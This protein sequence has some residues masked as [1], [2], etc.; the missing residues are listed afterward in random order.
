MV[1][2]NIIAAAK[3]RPPFWN[4]TQKY[5]LCSEKDKIKQINI[6]FQELFYKIID[7]KPP[8]TEIKNV[9]VEYRENEEE[10]NSENRVWFIF[11]L[12][13]PDSIYKGIKHHRMWGG[14]DVIGHVSGCIGLLLG[15]ALVKLPGGLFDRFDRI[16]QNKTNTIET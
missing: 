13:F 8:C 10:Q 16:K 5:P 3:C 6:H 12:V 7:P 9:H 14:G 15:Y 11:A 4:A 2:Q 1:L